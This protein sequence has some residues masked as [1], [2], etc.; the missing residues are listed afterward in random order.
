MPNGV[1]ISHASRDAEIAMT[2]CR[3]LEERGLRC[4]IARRDATPGRDWADEIPEAIGASESLVLIASEGTSEAPF[5][6][7]ELTMAVDSGKPIFTLRV[8][9]AELSKRVRFLV[10]TGTWVDAW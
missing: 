9:N 1:F 8:T 10:G 5:V 3:L 4:W 2:V 7:R 6:H